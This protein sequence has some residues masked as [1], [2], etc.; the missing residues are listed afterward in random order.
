MKR[1]LL[2]A[3][4]MVSLQLT[5]QIPVISHRKSIS[6]WSDTYKEY[7]DK[8]QHQVSTYVVWKDGKVSVMCPE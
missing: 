5:T 7:M 4:L 2:L 6:E 8:D 3:L 1:L